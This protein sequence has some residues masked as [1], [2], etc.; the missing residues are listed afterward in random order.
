MAKELGWVKIHRKIQ[1]TNGYFAE[2]FC[3]NMAWIDLLLLANHEDNFFRC[4]GIRVDVKRGQTGMGIDSFCE[5]WKWSRGKVERF[6]KELEK[7]LKII[8]QKNNV[9][10]VL[11]IVNYGQ[12]QDSDKANSKA[13]DN[14]DGQQAVKQTEPNKNGKNEKEE[15]IKEQP[16]WFLRFYHSTYEHYK[17]IFNGQSTTEDYF[18]EWKLLVDF[19]YKEKFEDLFECKFLTPHDYAAVNEQG[20][21]KEKWKPILKKI[22]ATGVKPEHN[23][24]FRIPQFMEYGEKPQASKLDK[25]N[26]NSWI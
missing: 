2:P 4:R 18:N 16:L 6:L 25:S 13:S 11:S 26:K 17:N 22:L 3:R 23:L 7:D 19:I 14:A 20:F 12:Y 1:D 24:F 8:R 9:T 10:T 5:R 21:T 15:K